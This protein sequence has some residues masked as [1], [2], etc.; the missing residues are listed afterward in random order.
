MYIRVL[1]FKISRKMIFNA[2]KNNISVNLKLSMEYEME[3]DES[4]QCTWHVG[5][6][7]LKMRTGR[8]KE[9]SSRGRRS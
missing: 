4:I 6:L 8:T 1:Y 3:G 5:S 9:W 2:H 7:L